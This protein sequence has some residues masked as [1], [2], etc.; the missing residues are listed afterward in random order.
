MAPEWFKLDSCGVSQITAVPAGGVPQTNL[1]APK[2][3]ST[4]M[5]TLAW[6]AFGGL[7]DP[8]GAGG[9]RRLF[10]SPIS[11]EPSW[12]E[13]WLVFPRGPKGEGCQN[14]FNEHGDMFVRILMFV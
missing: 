14:I 7:G 10:E 12:T 4:K 8:F 3:V 13:G 2:Q 11:L 6:N 5:G 9:V 1:F